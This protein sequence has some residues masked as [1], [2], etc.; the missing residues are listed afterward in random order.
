MAFKDNYDFE[1]LVNEAENLVIEELE[2]QLKEISDED[3]C[4]CEECVIDMAAL[5]LNRLTPKYRASFTGKIY[6]QQYY[7]GEYKKQVEDSVR[8]A[9][10][11]ISSNPSHP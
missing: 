10:E 1:L 4:K 2:K 8:Y 3:I 7:E 5:A 11:K 9:I 6:A